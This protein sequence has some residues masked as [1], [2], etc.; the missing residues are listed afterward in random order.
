MLNHIRKEKGTT[1]RGLKDILQLQNWTLSCDLQGARANAKTWSDI[2]G[3]ADLCRFQDIEHPRAVPE[4][5]LS[6]DG[7]FG[8]W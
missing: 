4:T 2:S 7:N 5:R 3:E 6:H 1:P 8:T